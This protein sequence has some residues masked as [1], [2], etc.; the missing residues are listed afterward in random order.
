MA[1]DKTAINVSLKR[2]NLKTGKGTIVS[3]IEKRV[4]SGNIIS[5]NIT[6]D[7]NET[8]LVGVATKAQEDNLVKSAT[9]IG[10]KDGEVLGGVQSIGVENINS[11]DL[12]KNSSIGKLTDKMPNISGL[13]TPGAIVKSLTGLPAPTTAKSGIQ[14]V[15][16]GAP[17]GIAKTVAAGQSKA[18]ATVS[19]VSAFSATIADAGELS[20][21]QSALPSVNFGNLTDTVKAVSPI[22]AISEKASDLKDNV[23]NTPSFFKNAAAV[24]KSGLGN[25]TSA[26]SSLTNK[27]KSFVSDTDKRFDTGIQSGFLQNVAEKITGNAA[28][29]IQ[30][31]VPGGIQASENERKQILASFTK[32]TEQDT[33]TG[34]KSVALKSSNISSR[35]KTFIE[36]ERIENTTTTTKIFSTNIEKKAR[37]AG[38]PE[39]EI[40]KATQEISIIEEASKRLDT[41]IGGSLVLDTDFLT[42][43]IPVSIDNSKWSG[44]TTSDD[45]FTYISSV[46]ELDLEFSTIQREITEVVVHATETYTNKNIGAIEI[47]NIHNE[48]GHDG[49]GYHYVIRRDGRLQRGRPVNKKG[50]HAPSN[51]HNNYSIG[52]VMVGGLD[53]PAGDKNPRFSAHTFTREQFSTLEKFLASFYRRYPGGQVFGHNDIDILEQDPYFDVIDYIESVF[54]KKNKI[55]NTLASQP[56]SPSDLVERTEIDKIGRTMTYRAPVF[57]EDGS[58]RDG[59]S[60]ATEENL[61]TN[62]TEQT[63]VGDTEKVVDSKVTVKPK[64]IDEERPAPPKVDSDNLP[65]P[66]TDADG[67]RYYYEWYEEENKWVV[68]TDYSNSNFAEETSS[69]GTTVFGG[70]ADVAEDFSS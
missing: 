13:K 49:I 56:L 8:S 22:S 62:I 16:S 17:A 37:L 27:V 45:V 58:I 26:V 32:K 3:S 10:L 7:I 68:V 41:T 38:V 46:E 44:R 2:E 50:D 36:N 64:V 18:T 23:K 47:N 5:N 30:G 39:E 52:I 60:K 20:S 4:V 1:L 15:G 42:S 25:V 29:F 67:T 14:A 12:I 59:I 40:T 31:I 53:S 57:E 35:M 19:D 28:G 65:V 6:K 63:T 54:R 43:A 11:N 9:K 51:K 55:S 34:V 21:I 70:D 33:A 66:R 61:I 69:E 48:L 24:V